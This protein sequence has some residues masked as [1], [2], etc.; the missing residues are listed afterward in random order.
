MQLHNRESLNLRSMVCLQ[1]E[2]DRYGKGMEIKRMKRRTIS[3]AAVLLAITF[4]TGCGNAIPELNDQQQELVVEYAAG[5][6]LKY[7]VNRERARRTRPQDFPRQSAPPFADGVFHAFSYP[8]N[9]K[10]RPP[11]TTPKNTAFPRRL[12]FAA[13]P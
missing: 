8:P 9:G 3:G 6:A 1:A 12:P 2:M 11:K 10:R 7:D 5:M 4:M 13:G